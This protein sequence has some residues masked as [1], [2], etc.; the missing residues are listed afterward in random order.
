M[1]DDLKP[2][3]YLVFAGDSY[4][5]AGGWDDFHGSYNTLQEAKTA[6][7]DAEKT[8]YDWTQIVDIATG[9]E[10]PS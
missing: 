5:T 2:K 6:A 10:L 9:Q 4:Y 1:S 3:R 8:R 7:R